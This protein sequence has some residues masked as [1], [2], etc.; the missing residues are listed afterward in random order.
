MK[1]NN[2]PH[3][4]DSPSL[5]RLDPSKGYIRG[6]LAWISERANTKKNKSQALT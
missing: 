4:G 5:D 3:Q 1:W 6:N 2:S